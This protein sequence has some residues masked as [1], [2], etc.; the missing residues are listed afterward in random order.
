MA[1]GHNSRRIH[2]TTERADSE[3]STPP[4]EL[5]AL[6]AAGAL[7]RAPRAVLEIGCGRAVESVFLACVGYS[8]LYAIDG[9]ADAVAAARKN[10]ARHGVSV[11]VAQVDLLQTPDELPSKW[12]RKFDLIL[13]RLCINNVVAA[14]A[15]DGDESAARKTYFARVASLLHPRGVLLLRDRWADD[16]ERRFRRS[17]FECRSEP[18]SEAAPYFDLVPGGLRVSARLIGDDTPDWRRL[19][20]M[21]PIMGDLMLLRRLPKRGAKAPRRRA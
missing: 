1:G 15:D 16:Q 10:I 4:L 12:P 14:I 11:Q 9:E 6:V 19:D 7:P 8:N 3:S 20:A 18:P 5:P 21:N 2:R 17:L 13:D